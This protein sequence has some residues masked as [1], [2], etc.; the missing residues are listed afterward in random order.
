MKKGILLVLL[1]AVLV[2][3]GAFAQEFKMSAGVG[4]FMG[5][6]FA[7]GK[8]AEVGSIKVT[9]SMPNWGYGVYGFYDVTYAEVSVGYFSGVADYNT[10]YDPESTYLRNSSDKLDITTLNLG[11]LGK[12]PIAVAEKFFIFPAVGIEYQL[13]SSVKQN[14]LNLQWNS[15][16]EKLTETLDALWIKAGVGADIFFTD[17]IFLRINALYG[18]R[19]PNKWESD[20]KY[21]KIAGAEAK[22]VLGH[23]L[24]AKVAVGWKF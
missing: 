3:S 14:G 22:S 7:G 20:D 5:G 6:D 13:F 1:M 23:G 16:G 2:V 18:V 24:T 8:T 21:M 12:Y 9:S 19:L 15:T 17:A 10:K 11:L 4:G